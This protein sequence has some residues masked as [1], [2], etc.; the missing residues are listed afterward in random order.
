[1]PG[2]TMEERWIKPK[3]TCCSPSTKLGWFAAAACLPRCASTASVPTCSCGQLGGRDLLDPVVM[4]EVFAELGERYSWG[5]VRNLLA[6][7]RAPLAYAH[8]RGVIPLDPTYDVFIGPPPPREPKVLSNAHL[9]DI[10]ANAR[11]EDD[12]LRLHLLMFTGCRQFEVAALR[13]EAVNLVSRQMRIMGKAAKLRTVPI[14]PALGELLVARHAVLGDRVV[15]YV[16]PEW[17]RRVAGRGVGFHDFR[18]TFATTLRKNGVQPSVLDKIM[19]WAARDIMGRFYDH[20]AAEGDGD[21]D[22]PR[23]RRRPDLRQ[24]AAHA[25]SPGT[26][27]SSRRWCFQRR[28]P[29]PRR[30]S[31]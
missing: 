2:L 18:R 29:P 20:V 9:R 24:E 4:E 27:L 11:N 28:L 23:L 3:C 30:V 5:T 14:H 12:V 21:G 6:Q 17:L 1:M 31:R 25:G 8:R 15:K 13:W 22:P 26:L 7:V 16:H 10:L 19:G